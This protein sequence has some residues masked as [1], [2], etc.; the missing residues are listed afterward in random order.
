MKAKATMEMRNINTVQPITIFSRAIEL[1]NE[2]ELQNRYISTIL[3]ELPLLANVGFCTII[4]VSREDD[5]NT[6]TSKKCNTRTSLDCAVGATFDIQKIKSIHDSVESA[7]KRKISIMSSKD[8]GKPVQVNLSEDARKFT[9]TKYLM[10][11][12][13]GMKKANDVVSEAS[14]FLKKL[15]CMYT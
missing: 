14:T 9:A 11:K 8:G 6:S 1:T 5:S 3:S 12:A 2:N 7:I 4:L 10:L 15:R 13:D